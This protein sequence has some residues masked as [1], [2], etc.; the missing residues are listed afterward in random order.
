MKNRV[1]LLSTAA[2]A[3]ALPTFAA[4]HAMAQAD[5]APPAAAPA[6]DETVVVVT[7]LRKSLMA[8]QDIKKKSDFVV[9]AITAEDIGKFPNANVADALQQIPGIAISSS[10]GEGQKITVRGLGPEFNTVLWNGRRIATDAT[11]RSFNFDTISS[12]LLGNTEVYKTTNVALQTGGIGSTINLGTIRPLDLRKPTAVFSARALYDKNADKTTPEAFA[13]FSRTFLDGHLGVLLAASYQRRDDVNQYATTAQWNPIDLDASQ[14]NLFANGQG[15]GAGTYW[16]PAK[17]TN[18]YIR[19]ERERKGFNATVQYKFSDDLVLSVDAMYS[20]FSVR[21]DGIEKAWFGNTST[22]QA[23]SMTA[24]GNNAITRYSF[25]NGPEYVKLNFDRAA[26]TTAFGANLKWT[27]NSFWSTT[28]DISTSTAKN[29]DGGHDAYFVIHGPD[30]VLTYDDTGGY[31]MPVGIDGAVVAYDPILF[32]A[33]SPQAQAAPPVGSTWDRNSLTGY[34]SWWTTRSGAQTNDEINEVRWDNR[35][36]FDNGWFHSARA[37]L[38]YTDQT[39]TLDTINADDVG[40]GN[41]GALGIPLPASLLYV[42]NKP[43]FLSSA[44]TPTTNK[45][46]DFNG[47]ALI[48]YLL[49]PEALA[50]RDQINGLAPG[51]S[52]ASILPRGYSPMYQPGSSYAVAEKSLSA[53]VELTIKGNLGNWPLTVI[54]GARYETTD[55][56]ATSAQMKLLDILNAPGSGGT[57]YV[58]VFDTTLSPVTQASKYHYVLPSVNAKLELSDQLTLR[59]AVSESLTRPNIGNL[60]PVITF[61]STLRPGGLVASGGNGSLHPYTSWNYDASLEW[62]YSRTNYVS[63]GYFYKKIDGLI[64]SS[65]V[66]TPITIANADG[67]SDANIQGTTANFDVTQYV[68]LNDNNV[69][70][71]ELAWQNS[72]KDAPGFLKNTG[73]TVSATIPWT[74]AKFDPTSFTNNGTFPGISK[75]YF[76]TAFYDDG[77]LEARLSLSHRDKYFSNMVTSTEPVFTLGSS[78]W[79]ARVSYNVNPQVQVFFDAMNLTNTPLRQTGRFSSEFLNYQETGARFDFGIRY[80]Y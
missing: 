24:D 63:V 80:K 78:Q 19:E 67:I 42:D 37:G 30:T 1:I 4:T 41:Y 36:S 54:G 17:L 35:F 14:L 11:D 49:S 69:S 10:N 15:N 62:Y 71:L 59:G 45:F 50:L 7:G 6:A 58:S 79:D 51:T 61:P 52:A 8:S 46:L 27:P 73:V 44:N 76:V 21:S 23:G 18:D 16:V 55:E 22:I 72:F 34:R 64:V 5:T 13:L 74:S 29:N 66:R 3:L 68:N 12:D 77:T 32:P 40:W 26:V 20:A 57:Q 48:N 43:D 9:D 38:A 28:L 47:E 56:K 39:K 33:G 75:S 31:R 70:G 53:Y 65:V 25:I 2:L 60:N